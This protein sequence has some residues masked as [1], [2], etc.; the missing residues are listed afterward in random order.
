MIRDA[1]VGLEAGEDTQT[2]AIRCLADLRAAF[3]T[4]GKDKLRSE[5][6][7]R[8]WESSKG[9]PWVEWGQTGR[10][11]TAN[12]VA[13]L[14]KGFNIQP[15]LIRFG[16]GKDDVAQGIIR[17]H[18]RERLPVSTTREGGTILRHS[19]RRNGNAYPAAEPKKGPVLKH[20]PRP[21]E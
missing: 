7:A 17:R 9:S 10:A 11:I 14:L 16:Q 8:P 15:R 6:V 2:L 18:A 21:P 13:K 12:A 4:A 3:T 5:V 1:A 19:R 20:Y